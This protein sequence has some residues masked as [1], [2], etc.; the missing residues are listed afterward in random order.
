MFG[1]AVDAEF[2]FADPDGALLQVFL[3]FGAGGGKVGDFVDKKGV[4]FRVGLGDAEAGFVAAGPGGQTVGGALVGGGTRDGGGGRE[5]D[6]LGNAHDL[7]VSH[8]LL[9]EPVEVAGVLMDI[10]DSLERFRFRRF[11]A[12]RTAV[13]HGGGGGEGGGVEEV[14]A[15]G[16]FHER[17]PSG[18][19]SQSREGTAMRKRLA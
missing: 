14:P 8:Q 18:R 19:G 2:L 12:A 16:R 6:G 1:V 11:F 9:V 13:D 17:G 7:L 3:E 15:A 5:H 10:H 4:V